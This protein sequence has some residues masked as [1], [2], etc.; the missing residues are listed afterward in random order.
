MEL[1][2]KALKLIALCKNKGYADPDD[3]FAAVSEETA[4]GICMNDGCDFIADVTVNEKEGYC[5]YCDD[6]SVRSILFFIDGESERQREIERRARIRRLND[7]LRSKF[8]GG[9]IVTSAGVAAL[10]DPVKAQVLTKVQTFDAFSSDN[11]PYDEHDFACFEIDG[12]K[13]FWKIDYYDE[14]MKWGSDDPADP[15]KT[16]RVLT[17]MLSNEY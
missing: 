13:Y 3:A 10:S 12:Q 8:T 17:I 6:C 2:T 4:P 11:D 7:A 1:T 16:T 9:R 5:E 14:R 15:L